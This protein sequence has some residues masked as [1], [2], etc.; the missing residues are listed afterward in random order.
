MVAF[1]YIG[2][3]TRALG[4][5]NLCKVPLFIAGFIDGFPRQFLLGCIG[6]PQKKH[7]C[8]DLEELALEL[9]AVVTVTSSEFVR[10]LCDSNL[11]T[12]VTDFTQLIWARTYRIG[13]AISKNITSNTY[14]MA[15]NYGR[16]GNVPEKQVY[17]RGDP[18]S[19]CQW[20]TTC[21]EKYTSLCGEADE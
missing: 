1:R 15:C 2:R 16:E 5:A 13:C 20:A 7:L 17:R 10:D 11:K 6:P 12:N 19:R 4:A 21:N 9:V 14:Y 3:C 18:C 8:P